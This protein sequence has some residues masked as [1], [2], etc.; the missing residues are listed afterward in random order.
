[1]E[2][3]IK[4]TFYVDGFNFYYGLKESKW[5][6]YYWLNVVKLFEKFIQPHQELVAV[7]YFSA[8]PHHNRGKIDR[9]NLYFNANKTN[10]K[11]KLILGKYQSKDYECPEC[12]KT[13][14]IPIEKQTDINISVAI[15]DDLYS[16]RTDLV[17]LVTADSDLVP[18]VRLITKTM[19]KKLFIYFPPGRYSNELY[20]LASSKFLLKHYE[21][22]FKKSLFPLTVINND[23]SFITC[24]D[25]WNTGNL[26]TV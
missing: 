6:K 25:R 23:D 10:P 19:K 5:K 26:T 11:F 13:Y 3:K 17:C 18:V 14:Q 12:N 8:I 2:N 16:N 22:N 15:L 20:T 7:K 24:P 21:N 9:Q 4:V 1:M